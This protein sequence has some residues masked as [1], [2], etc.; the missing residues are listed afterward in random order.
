MENS[1][2]TRTF[3]FNGNGGS[4]FGI[5]FVNFVLTVLTLGLYYPWAKANRLKYIYQEAEFEGSSFSF[6]GTGAEIFKGM[7]KAI[8]I[9]ILLIIPYVLGL[10]SGN[11]TALIAGTIVYVM[12]LVTLIPI[13]IT[14]S[15]RYRLSRTS[16]KGIQFGY[17][18][19]SSD[20]LKIYA[21]GIL[22][23]IFTLGFYGAWLYMDLYRK[24]V[25]NA[26]VGS[27]EF[28]FNGRGKEF[29]LMNIEGY[30]GTIFTLGIYYFWWKKNVHNYIF[31]N[32]EVIQ[33]EERRGKLKSIVTGTDFLA[34]SLSNLLLLVV[35]LGFA[36]P[37]VMIRTARFYMKNLAVLGT[38][39]FDSIVQT[40]RDYKDA[41]GD[42]VLDA[43]DF[44]LI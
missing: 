8:G 7:I 30:F 11:A 29:L 42:S 31:N 12:G 44:Q 20:L 34:L 43:V 14:G 27:L 10:L 18:G 2:A 23:T 3:K 1:N 6:H 16:W 17:R 28:K 24:V 22:F 38:V 32:I 25:E 33:D 4:L 35:S 41:T 40:E 5:L 9:V 19:K 26:R 39:D 13:A 37:W 15:L 36:Y 21:K